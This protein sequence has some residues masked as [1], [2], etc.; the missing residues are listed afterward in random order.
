M[1]E[2]KCILMVKENLK[3]PTLEKLSILNAYILV[4]ESYGR[5]AAFKFEPNNIP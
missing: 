4:E 2:S 5:D 1:L 3:C